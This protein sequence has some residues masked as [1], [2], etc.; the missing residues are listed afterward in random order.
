VE[1][2]DWFRWKAAIRLCTAQ[3]IHQS[4]C[5]IPISSRSWCSAISSSL[6]ASISSS[7]LGPVRAPDNHGRNWIYGP[8]SLVSSS[9]ISLG[10]RAVL[11]WLITSFTALRM[12]QVVVVDPQMGNLQNWDIHLPYRL[13]FHA[14]GIQHQRLR[15]IWQVNG[16]QL[17]IIHRYRLKFSMKSV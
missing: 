2:E 9:I 17:A 5:R 4:R 15:P 16:V 3:T 12:E 11:H 14:S 8:F 10:P 6:I 1:E 7:T 13:E